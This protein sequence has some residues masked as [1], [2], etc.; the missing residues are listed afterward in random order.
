LEEDLKARTEKKV[1]NEISERIL[2]EAGL[3]FQVDAT[4]AALELPDGEE[5]ARGIRQLFEDQP[6]AEWR[7]HIAAVAGEDFTRDGEP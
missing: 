3:D 2:R 6:D 5:L 7:A 4:M 1:R